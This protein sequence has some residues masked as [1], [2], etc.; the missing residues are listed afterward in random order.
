MVNGKENAVQVAS[1]V[2]KNFPTYY[3]EKCLAILSLVSEILI[4]TGT[5]EKKDDRFFRP[6]APKA[7]V[8]IEEISKY[9]KCKLDG[10]EKSNMNI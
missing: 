8:Y 9:D 10:P 2:H 7:K 1:I 6:L 4:R 5:G 3:S